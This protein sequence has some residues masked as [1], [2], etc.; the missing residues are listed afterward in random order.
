MPFCHCKKNIAA[1]QSHLLFTLRD[2]SHCEFVHIMTT[3]YT[4]MK[5][6]QFEFCL[7]FLEFE[8]LTNAKVCQFKVTRQCYYF[9]YWIQILC[10][11]YCHHQ[12]TMKQ[13]FW[14]VFLSILDEYVKKMQLGIYNTF[15]QHSAYDS[16]PPKREDRF[17]VS[18]YFHV[19]CNAVANN[20]A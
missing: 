15:I 4:F 7:D 16:Y 14:W 9:I 10:A 19:I 12:T 20:N 11:C 17:W 8:I 2:V 13:K 18:P 3:Q 5:S 1:K 6:I